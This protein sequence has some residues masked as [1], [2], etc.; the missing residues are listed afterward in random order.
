MQLNLQ[1]LDRRRAPLG[2]IYGFV[3]AG[4]AIIAASWL[5]LDLPRMVCPLRRVA[6]LACPTCGSTR[7]VEAFLGGDFAAAFSANPLVF[8]VFVSAAFW[9]LAS[10]SLRILG[11]PA[12]QLVCTPRDR[13]W[14]RLAALLMVLSGWAYVIL[15][16]AARL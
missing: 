11:W 8:L 12:P 15:A 2:T 3:L 1:P 14:I 6:G 5:W 4:A 9:S 16:E 10:T 13:L 7:M